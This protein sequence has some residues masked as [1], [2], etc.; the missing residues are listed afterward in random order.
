VPFPGNIFQDSAIPYKFANVKTV[1]RRLETTPFRPSW[2]RSPG[3]MQNTNES[4]ID[5]LAAAAGMDP[6]DFRLKYLDPADKRGIEL[7]QRLAQLANW[8]KRPSPQKSAGGSVAKGRGMSYVKYELVRTYVGV[9]AE[10][11][12][13]RSSGEIRVPKF[14]VAHDCGQIINP[15]GTQKP[16]RR[17]RSADGEPHPDR[18]AKIQPFAGDQPRLGTRSSSSRRC[19]RSSSI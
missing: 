13:D 2:I 19:R 15:D 3:R 16:A 17:L 9:V 8:Q 6:L 4:F 1:C 18:G 14:Y 12:V 10:V 11:E 7:L 5:E